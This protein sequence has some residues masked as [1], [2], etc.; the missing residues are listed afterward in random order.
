VLSK[1]TGGATPAAKA[2]FQR[3]AHR[4]HLESVFGSGCH[5]VVT[6]LE[7]EIQKCLRDA[8]AN[9]VTAMVLTVSLA[10]AISEKSG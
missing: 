5:Q 7:G 8:G 4:H 10:A 2:S 1:I 9:D 3:K 6:L